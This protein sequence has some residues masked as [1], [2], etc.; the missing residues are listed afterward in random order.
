MDL[1]GCSVEYIT[2]VYWQAINAAYPNQFK[3]W[4]LKNTPGNFWNEE[5]GIQATRWLIEE[6][7]KWNNND[8]KEKISQKVF[9]DNELSGMIQQVYHVVLGKPSMQPIPINNSRN[10]NYLV[11]LRIFGIT[12]PEYR[13]SN[14]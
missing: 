6:K 5:T 14:G 4:E 11:F 3:E 2:V 1:P 8:I 13:L 7:L 12:K 9:I 10:G